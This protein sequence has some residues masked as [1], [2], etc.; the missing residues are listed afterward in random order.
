LI[1]ERQ[2]IQHTEKVCL[3]IDKSVENAS[4]RQYTKQSYMSNDCFE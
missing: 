2:K 4:F 1:Y 3:Q